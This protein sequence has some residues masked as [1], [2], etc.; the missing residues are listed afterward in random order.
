[1]TKLLHD[2][3]PKVRDAI[4]LVDEAYYMVAIKVH[5]EYAGIGIVLVQRPDHED[6]V[7][8]EWNDYHLGDGAVALYSGHYDMTYEEGMMDFEARGR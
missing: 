3:V 8:W 6:Y 1:V 2:F 4:W 5:P 7:T